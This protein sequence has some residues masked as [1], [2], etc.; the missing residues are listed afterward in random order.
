MGLTLFLSISS[1]G[2]YICLT[3]VESPL[4]LERRVV[5]AITPISSS[6][7]LT[8]VNGGF[9]YLDASISVIP[10]MEISSGIFKPKSLIALIAAIAI[11][12]LATKNAVGL[13]FDEIRLVTKL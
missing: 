10:T 5:A 11:W 6:G 2:T 12:S 3:A 8:V 9:K 4:T 1:V 7:I 13:S